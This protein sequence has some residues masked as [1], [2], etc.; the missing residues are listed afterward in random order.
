MH[1]K[2]KVD[3]KYNV[4][5]GFLIFIILIAFI[6]YVMKKDRNLNPIEKVVKDACLT[7]SSVIYKPVNFVK[8]KIKENNEKNQIYKEYKQLKEEKEQIQANKALID[9]LKKENSDLKK[10]LE[11][12]STLS[13]YD[14]INATVISRNAGYWYN[15]MTIDKGEANGLTKDM[16]VVTNEGLI[17]KIIDTSYLY[18]TVRLLTSEELGQKVS[19]KIKVSDDKYVYGLLSS[20]DT[21]SKAFI[22]EGISENVD[23]TEGMIVT[24]TGMS[25]IFPSGILIG[26]IKE[27]KKDNFDLAT[28]ALVKPAS[29]FDDLSFVSVLKRKA[30]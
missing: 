20:Y 9:E 30:G 3:F 10:L 26:T 14:K 21:A 8:N 6:I 15:T 27:I 18:S 29:H 16:A 7:V 1:K 13:E 24:T 2:R 17:G 25:N 4:L 12:N 23:L 22:I 5:I 28:I 11:L 19:I